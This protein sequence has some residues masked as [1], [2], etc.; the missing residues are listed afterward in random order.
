MME[1]RFADT[2]HR[3]NLALPLLQRSSKPRHFL[4]SRPQ[5]SGA[6]LQQSLRLQYRFWN[7]IRWRLA[8]ASFALLW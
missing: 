2:V 7:A 4:H 5:L 3:L 6:L 1:H 8:T